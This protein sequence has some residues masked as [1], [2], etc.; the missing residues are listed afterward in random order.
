V[1][2][3]RAITTLA[4]GVMLLSLAACG[5][6]EMKDSPGGAGTA[7]SGASAPLSEDQSWVEAS[8]ETAETLTRDEDKKGL[9]V[10]STRCIPQSEGGGSPWTHECEI[11]YIYG[12]PASCEVA[13]SESGKIR[14]TR[15]AGSGQNGDWYRDCKKSGAGAE[16]DRLAKRQLAACPSQV[17]GR[18]YCHKVVYGKPG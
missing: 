3:K 2:K 9:P 12:P 11:E 1:L 13:M 4:V 6:D 10:D 15:C 8:R 16:C 18:R 17:Q 7:P 5:S 14:A